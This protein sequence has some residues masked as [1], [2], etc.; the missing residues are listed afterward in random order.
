MPAPFQPL[1]P[2]LLVLTT[3]SS[4]S[5]AR[6]LARVL[7]KEKLAA[8]VNLIPDTESHYWW[9]GRV[10]RAGEILLLI[11]TKKSAFKKVEKTIRENH[12]YS[13][14]E[15]IGLPIEKGSRPYLDWLAK[16]IRI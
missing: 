7:L 8:C 3:A 15:I 5:E 10:E 2:Y 14:P 1:T 11:K 16:E 6:K 13:V 4:R 12:S 9:K